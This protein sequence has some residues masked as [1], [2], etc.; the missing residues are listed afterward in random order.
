MLETKDDHKIKDT[1]KI[2]FSMLKRYTAVA[3]AV[4]TIIIAG[5]LVWD[6]QHENKDAI[7]LAKNEARAIFNKDLAFRM[8][9]ASHGGVYVTPDERTPPNPYLSH[10][11]DRDVITTT[12]KSLTLMNPAYIIRQ[13][14]E[15][16]ESTYGVKGHITSLK[17]LNPINAPDE[18]ERSTLLAFEQGVN[19]VTELSDIGKVPHLRFMEPLITTE[20][21][22]K[23]HGHQGYKEG[24]IRGGVSVS[25]PL[26]PFYSMAWTGIATQLWTHGAIYLFG[27]GLIGFVSVRSKQRVIERTR[28]QEE[29][30]KAAE[31]WRTTFDSINDFVSICDK[32]F[33]I[34]RVN[35]AFAD[36]FKEE[37]AKLIGKHCY[38]VFH[39][40]KEPLSNCPHK[41]TIETKKPAMAEY[42][43]PHLGI[44]LEVATSPIFD[45]R[46]EVVASVHIA[47]DITERKKMEEQLIVTD[48]LASIGELASGIAHELNN[49]LTGVISFS[50]LLLD[51]EVSDD[52]RKDLE[53]INREAKR[54]AGVV[55][56]LLSFA[57]KHP[58]EKQSVDVNKVI[59][60]VLELRAYEQKV[61]NIE[62]S[63]QFAPGLPQVTAN[64]F[65]LQQ[66]FMNIIINAEHFMTEAH[67]R[68]TLTISTEQVGDIIRVSFADD[69]PGIAKENLGHMFDPFF[70]TKEVGKGT[71]LGLSISHGIITS[72]GGT[73]YAE[74]ELG[75]GAT[76]V[77]ELP[78]SK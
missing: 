28:S 46:G 49:P 57:R 74:S 23:C 76:F 48:R 14:M 10:I 25:I 52:V 41:K 39:G 3:I 21:C 4:W 33:R 73:I 31:E 40:T 16:Y 2:S 24:D 1:S 27:L 72:H 20:A 51:Q 43:E 17:V 67:G 5:S 19:E 63:T 35:K 62:V 7:E 29:L 45:D 70:T 47:R 30:R 36:I 75:Q 15:D 66:V 60:E 53:V 65:E 34:V 8:W 71:G 58:G 6:I 9:A 56:G 42:F 26:T 59:Q 78:V 55:K 68:G 12:G 54:T 18:W 22:L 50:E 64:G 32:D 77:I 44:H 69:G 11:T 13:V 38:E 37:P 61:N